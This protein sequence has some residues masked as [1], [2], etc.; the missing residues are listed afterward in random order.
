MLSKVSNAVVAIYPVAN[1]KNGTNWLL[2]VQMNNFLVNE[3]TDI[4]HVSGT[5]KAFGL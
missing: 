3:N 4:L 1:I 5:W 2:I